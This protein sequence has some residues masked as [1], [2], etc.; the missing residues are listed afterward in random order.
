MHA[1]AHDLVL[2]VCRQRS[3]AELYVLYVRPSDLAELLYYVLLIAYQPDTQ[4]RM[5]LRTAVLLLYYCACV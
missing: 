1:T 5:C 3:D 4:Q 2:I